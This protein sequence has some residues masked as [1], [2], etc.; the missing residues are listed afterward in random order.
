[1]TENWRVFRD[2]ACRLGEQAQIKKTERNNDVGFN[3]FF[4]YGWKRFYL[5]WYDFEHPSALDSCP[6]SV[7]M[8]KKVKCIR[9]AMFAEL[10]PKGK[11]N[12]HRDPFAGSLRY[13][14]DL[15]TPNSEKCYIDVHGQRYWWKD[16]E[17]M[18][19]DETFV[20]EARNDA[21]K[22]RLILFCDIARLQKNHHLQSI[23]EWISVKVMSAAVSPNTAA[24]KTGFINRLSTIYWMYDINRKKLKAWSKNVYLITKWVLLLAVVFCFIFYL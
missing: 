11:L 8:L 23:A 16:G 17:S 13:H 19:F 10:P 9:A 20:H 4:K 14:L 12:P 2:E 5:K 3:S 18:I 22:T 6:R 21:E 7:A 24:D 15:S 1:M